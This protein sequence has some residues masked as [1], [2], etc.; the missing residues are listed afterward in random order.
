MRL[1]IAEKPDLAKAI[2]EGLGGGSQKKGFIECGSDIVTWC[3]GHML[4]LS[5][6]EDYN[7]EHKTWNIDHLPII[8]IPWKYK[9]NPKSKDQLKIILDLIKK[10]DS[11]VNAGD[12]DEEGQLLVDEILEYVGNKKPVKRVLIN[13][14]NTELVKKAIANLRDNQDFFGMSQAALARSVADQLYGYNMTRGYTLTAQKQGFDGTLPVGRVQTPVLGLVVNRDRQHEAHTKS[15]YYD[16]RGNFTADPIQV[17]F[18]KY[19][20]AEHTPTDEK[21]RVTSEEFLKGVV[22]NCTGQPMK[23]ISASTEAKEASPPLPFSLLKLQAAASKKFKLKPDQVKDITQALRE[24]YK[25]ITYNR[26]DCQYLSEE[27]HGDAADVIQAIN[28]TNPALASII[29]KTDSGIKS[30]AFNSA[31][32]SAHHAIIPTIATA[33]FSKLTKPEQDVYSLIAEAYLVQFFP[34]QKFSETKIIVECSGHKFTAS[35]REILEA[36]WTAIFKDVTEDQDEETPED[37]KQ[38]LQSIEAGASGTCSSCQLEKKETKPPSKY[39]F[40]TLLNDLTRVAK[41]VEDLKLK[42]LLQEKDK[43][44]KGESGGIGTPATRDTI[45]KGLMDRGFLVEQGKFIVSSDLARKFYD[46]LPDYARH[47]DMTALWHEQQKEIEEGGLTVK[48]FLD[49]LT[50]SVSSEIERLKKD[51]LQLDI[52]QGPE[53]PKCKTGFLKRRKGKTGFFWGCSSYPECNASYPDKK[54]DPDTASF[55]CPKCGK[56]LRQRTGASGKFWGCSGFPECKTSY[57]DKKG[58][59]DTAPPKPKAVFNCPECGLQLRQVKGKFGLFWSCFNK[60]K[61]TKNYKDIKGKPNLKG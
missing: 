8:N 28:Q 41:Y 23:I 42:K 52:K 57:P 34:N 45:I 19:R 58:K 38:N 47:P 26:S 2:V 51:G 60:P 12:P 17:F 29:D 9:A 35:S 32:V 16:L 59:P 54:G 5:D 14:L 13:D 31:N 61:C 43:D 3:F 36:G 44:K 55:P 20:P 39:T 40:A 18:A 37:E 25:L 7:P 50:G 10:A 6:P 15:F 48:A 27:Q 11:I 1:F 33:D 56:D 30:R 22:E 24:K 4:Q 21:G 49:E 46:I 53:C